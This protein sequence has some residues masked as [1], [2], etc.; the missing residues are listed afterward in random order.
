[1]ER[2]DKAPREMRG[3]SEETRTTQ[4]AG[5]G[6]Q[7]LGD[8]KQAAGDANTD[9]SQTA[10]DVPRDERGVPQHVERMTLADQEMEH[11][12]LKSESGNVLD[13]LALQDPS[14]RS[15]ERVV[16]RVG[17][18]VILVLV[19][20]ILFV[21]V[22][23]KNLQLSSLPNFEQGTSQS[24]V[25]TAIHNGVLWGG[26][27]VRFPGGT[28]FS[29]IDSAT[30]TLTLTIS[31]DSVRSMEQALSST[32]TPVMALAMNAFEDPSV[33][34]V[35][36][37]VRAHVDEETGAITARGS[38]S[39]ADVLVITWQRDELDPA[40]YHCTVDGYQASPAA[41]EDQASTQVDAAQSSN[42]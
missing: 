27:I 13:P 1:M 6:N 10:H 40:R 36:A 39:F 29:S 20:G 26:E 32:Q 11:I 42:Q 8:T 22:A 31:D 35:V 34:T 7:A 17:M 25:E 37:H 14:G 28:E 3:P 4:A 12:R 41:S 9:A 33:K 18:F 16:L 2:D 23:C 21:Q 24:S 5:A 15:V 19:L 30:G 38:E